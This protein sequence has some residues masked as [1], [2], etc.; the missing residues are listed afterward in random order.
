HSRPNSPADVDAAYAFTHGQETHM[1]GRLAGKKA[2]ITAAGQG[3]GRATAIAMASEGAQVFATDVNPKLVDA[4]RGTP[5]VTPSVLDVLD[6]AAIAATI[7]ALPALDV[8]FNCA[9]YVHNGSILDCRAKG[10]DFTFI[11]KLAAM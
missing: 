1:S 7:E 5:N 2:L 11:M 4:L 3:I 9:G 8:L 6:D 10:C